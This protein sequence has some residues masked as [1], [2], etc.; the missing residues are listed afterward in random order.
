MVRACQLFDQRTYQ[1]FVQLLRE[2]DLAE[3]PDWQQLLLLGKIVQAL[4]ATV[5]P[6][7]AGRRFLLYAATAPAM[8]YADLPLCWTVAEPGAELSRACLEWIE[9]EDEAARL[10]TPVGCY[11]GCTASGQARRW[12]DCRRPHGR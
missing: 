9:S 10:M 12:S 2:T 5:G 3:V 8:M 6:V 4:D 11:W 1:E 7:A